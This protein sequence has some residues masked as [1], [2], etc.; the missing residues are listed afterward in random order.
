MGLAISGMHYAAMYGTTIQAGDMAGMVAAGN[1]SHVLD[2]GL[3]AMVVAVV[4][5]VICGASL[6]LLVPTQPRPLEVAQPDASAIAIATATVPIMEA[7]Q[8]TSLPPVEPAATP[9]DDSGIAVRLGSSMIRLEPRAIAAIRADGRYTHLQDREREY[10]CNLSIT[11]LE[12][13]LDP[14]HFMRVHRSHILQL[15]QV[16]AIR[17]KGDG[18][19]AVIAARSEIQVPVSRSALPKL[20]AR[21][22]L[23]D[24]PDQPPE[25]TVVLS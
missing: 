11:E 21:L 4:A 23:P 10:F 12:R 19:F 25:A 5:F 9:L 22:M 14:R 18:A 17:R 20:K 8:P 16:K 13:R 6:L 24:H 7:S 15:Q 2:R 1:D 3:L